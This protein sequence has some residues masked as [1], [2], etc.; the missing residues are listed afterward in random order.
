[1]RNLCSPPKLIFGFPYASQFQRVVEPQSNDIQS[2]SV[3]HATE[4]WLLE[5]Q[6]TTDPLSSLGVIAAVNH[7]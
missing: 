1:M 2:F 3:H 7:W 5:A 6:R 4:S